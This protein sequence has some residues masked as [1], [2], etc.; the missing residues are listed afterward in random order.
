MTFAPDQWEPPGHREP[1]SGALPNAL[2]EADA[3][4]SAQSDLSWNEV[5]FLLHSIVAASRQWRVA[6]QRIRDEFS[7]KPRG[8]WILGLIYS[9][10]V[11]FPADLAKFFQCSPS[12]ITGE[13]DRVISAGLVTTRKHEAD[14]RQLELLLTP[15]GEKVSVSI[16]ATVLEMV[17]KPLSDYS[18]AD[19]LFCARMLRVFADELR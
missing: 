2:D 7:L 8:P 5:G 9:G 19:V 11:V 13:L 6:T 14:G 18:R 1:A 17:R 16:S 12:L 3:D 4:S 10:K 15:L